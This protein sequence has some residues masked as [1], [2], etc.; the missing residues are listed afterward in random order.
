M[1]A[2]RRP[3]YFQ[4]TE[5]DSTLGRIRGARHV[6][7]FIAVYIIALPAFGA[8]YSLFEQ[9][10][11]ATA[12][13]GAFAAT[14]DDPS[15]IFYNVAGI[16]YQ[17]EQK[18]MTG[19]TVIT[20]SSQF[21]SDPGS[22]FPGANPDQTI[23]GSGIRE[24]YEEHTF[25]LPNLYYIHPIGENMTFGIGQFTPFGL[26]T[27]WQNGDRF[28]GRFISRDANLKTTS[29]QPS[30]AMKTSDGRFAWG[31][32]IELRAARV[33]L[34]RNLGAINPFTQR[35]ADIAAVRLDGDW[36]TGVGWNAGVIWSPSD[37]WRVGLSHRAEMEIDMRGDATFR[38]ILTGNPQFDAL[39]AAGL[40]PDQPIETAIPFPSFTHFGIATTMIPRW[41]V[42]LNVVRMNWSV[43]DELEIRF[44]QTPEINETIGEAWKDVYSYRIGAVRPVTSNWSI[45][46][47]AVYDETP[48]PIEA[49]GPLLP[50]SDRAGVSFGF[51]FDNGRWSFELTEFFLQFLQR[52]T[53]GLN[54]H[55]FNGTYDTNANLVSVN[56]GYTF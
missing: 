1:I 25:I 6:S 32:G 35:I 19:G 5:G 34:G 24:F 20:Y 4:P 36:E 23:P 22:P 43:F 39:I 27:D 40:P 54:Q 7:F 26:R 29:I 18:V 2:T 45:A 47:G 33:V 42:E 51:L 38:Q 37:Q 28:S 10:A 13:G 15:A 12:M 8:G 56:V 3:G 50:D 11:K 14:A 46:L 53:R 55:N 9:G 30:F 16:A 21:E 44:L 41:T 48:Q 31:A 49:V 17:R 52:D